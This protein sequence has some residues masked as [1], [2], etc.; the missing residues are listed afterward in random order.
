MIT[1]VFY[2]KEPALFVHGLWQYDYG[3]ILRIQGLQLPT[4]V[5]IHFSLDENGGISTTRI[6]VTKDGVTDVVI[7]DAMLENGGIDQNYKIYAFIYLADVA[8]GQT[9]KKISINVKSRPR[10]EAFDT[11]EDA[12]L[13][14]EVIAAVNESA[15]SARSAVV[16]AESWTIG[17][18]GTREGEDENNARYYADRAQDAVK[19][20]PGYVQ[21]AK[22]DIDDYVVEKEDELKGEPGYTPQKGVDYFDGKDGRDGKDGQDG[23]NGKDGS[24]ANVTTE[25]VKTA[26]GYTPAKNDDV[27]VLSETLVRLQKK[28]N[29]IVD[30]NEVAY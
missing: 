16:A 13:F 15:E 30:G 4:A 19:E 24:D 9:V 3:Q 29:G 22:K 18:T 1:A 11:P 2:N 28:V 25:N 21:N 17:G 8:S 5:E 23:Q 20:I 10:P 27:T 26:L 12:E 7:P 14:R 6:G